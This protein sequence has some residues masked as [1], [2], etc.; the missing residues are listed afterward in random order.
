MKKSGL[1]PC[2]V[3]KSQANKLKISDFELYMLL[4]LIFCT[5]P[6]EHVSKCAYTLQSSTAGF[7]SYMF[8]SP[9][10]EYFKVVT[11]PINIV[12]TDK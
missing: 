7:T 3:L 5:I 9:S 12:S 8:N 6:L 4:L 1:T 2:Q 10:E 11:T